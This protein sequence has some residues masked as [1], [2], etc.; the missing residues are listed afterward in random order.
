MAGGDSGPA[1]VPGQ[2][3]KSRLVKA[4]HYGNDLQMPP[5]GKLGDEQIAVL[6][7][8][9]KLGAPWPESEQVVRPAPPDRGLQ[10]HR[11]GPRLLVVP[12]GGGSAGAGGQGRTMAADLD[13][14]LR[15]R[16]AGSHTTCRPSKPADKRTLIRRATFDLIGLPPTPEEIEAFLADESPEAFARVVDRLLASPHYGERWARHWLDVARYGEDQAHTFQARKYPHGFRYRDWVVRAF[17]DDMPYDR[18]VRQQI[19]ADLLDGAERA[20]AICRRWASSPSGPVYYGDRKKLDQMRRPHR[21]AHP[22]LPRADGR[23]RPL[24]RS[25]VRPDLDGRTTT[26]WPA[27]SP[28]REYD[29]VAAGVAGG[30]RGGRRPS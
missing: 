12:P 13:R 30:S 28:A 11:R 29:E 26:R 7:N 2:P 10:D 24:P 8:W 17:N 25:Q 16:A 6:S 9:V 1:I 27:S 4:I 21:H 14:P 3:D 19:A 15:P 20:G 22:R 18:F 5:E 23:L